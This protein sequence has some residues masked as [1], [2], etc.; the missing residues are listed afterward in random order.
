MS[1]EPTT[2]HAHA[3]DIEAAVAHEMTLVHESIAAER[4]EARELIADAHKV[5]M[6]ITNREKVPRTLF[7][8]VLN[9]MTVWL[10]EHGAG[11]KPFP[12]QVNR[13]FR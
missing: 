4:R 8:P 9:R 3:A 6:A 1:D 2:K 12:K 11:S 10:G 13:A 5:L 7:Y